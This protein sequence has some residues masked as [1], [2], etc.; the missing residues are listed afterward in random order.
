MPNIGAVVRGKQKHAVSHSKMSLLLAF[1]K[2][3]IQGL[4][5]LMDVDYTVRQPITSKRYIAMFS[6]FQDAVA[7]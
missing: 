6:P 3:L 5:A 4:Q 7:S 2:R 1:S